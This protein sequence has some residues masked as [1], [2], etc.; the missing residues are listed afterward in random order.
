MGGLLCQDRSQTG[1][2]NHGGISWG[3][4]SR[5]S[6]PWGHEVGDRVMG[7][8]GSHLQPAPPHVPLQA[9]ATLRTWMPLWGSPACCPPAPRDRRTPLAHHISAVNPA[10]APGV[11]PVIP[12]RGLGGLCWGGSRCIT[13]HPLSPVGRRDEEQVPPACSV[14]RKTQ[15]TGTWEDTCEDS[16]ALLRGPMKAPRPRDVYV[17]SPWP[18]D[19]PQSHNVLWSP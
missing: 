3:C 14:P 15:H 19:V 18:C 11:A 1:T 12:I 16:T 10:L 2:P 13:P 7:G 9:A 8:E 5:G 17:T 6:W 4:T